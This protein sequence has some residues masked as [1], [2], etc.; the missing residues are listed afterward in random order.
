MSRENAGW[1][2]FAA[3]G[4]GLGWTGLAGSFI[5]QPYIAWQTPVVGLK[6]RNRMLESM[7]NANAPGNIMRLFFLGACFSDA[8]GHFSRCEPYPHRWRATLLLS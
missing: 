7:L 3:L 4:L 8:G 1:L 5:I 2:R 6:R